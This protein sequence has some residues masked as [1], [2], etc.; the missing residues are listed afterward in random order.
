MPTAMNCLDSLL[1]LSFLALKFLMCFIIFNR[2][3]Q[4]IFPL[5]FSPWHF[6]LL[7]STWHTWKPQLITKSSNKSLPLHLRGTLMG[8]NGQ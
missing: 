6:L 2:K 4:R 5:S 1:L 3:V 8:M 7:V